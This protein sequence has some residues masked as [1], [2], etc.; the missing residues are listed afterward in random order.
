MARKERRKLS[1]GE[2]RINE[3]LDELIRESGDPKEI[4]SRNGLLGQLTKR[5]AERVLDAEMQAHLGYSRNAVQ[6]R[7]SG[8][9]RNGHSEKTIQTDHQEVELEVPRDRNGTFEPQ[10]VPKRRRRLAG[11]DEKVLYLYA[12]GLSTRQIQEQLEDLYG[13]EVSP[14]LISLV[15]DAVMDEARAWQ[16]RSLE[17]VYPVMYFD[18][19]FVKSREAGPVQTK[20]VY[21]ALGITMAGHKELLGLWIAQSEGAK[22]WQRVFNEM[23][24]RGMQDCLVA[25]VDGLAGLPEAIEAVFPKAQ[26]QLCIVHK[27]R[28]TLSYVSYKERKAVAGDLRKIYAAPTLTGAELALEE[29][30]RKWEGRYPMLAGLWRGSWDRLTVF[31]D[32]PPEIR[33]VIYTTNALESVNHSL[34]RVIKNK[35][36]FPS[37]EAVLKMLYLGAQRAARKWT[38]PIRDWQGALHQFHLLYPDRMSRPKRV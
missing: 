8:N 36:T 27:V 29:F 30:E 17:E 31:F 33:K 6:G 4:L 32:Y 25:C 11:F 37:D 14:A 20:A 13:T 18:A 35:K 24:N 26:V 28:Q 9:S 19:L 5:L 2:K 22:F 10:L 12:Q 15:T 16:N 7:N 38:M 23:K 3:M 21:L 34:R 1:E